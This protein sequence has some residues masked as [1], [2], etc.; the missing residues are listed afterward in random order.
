MN[1]MA[2][3]PQNADERYR[4]MMPN[5]R[6]MML[7]MK[8]G[9]D[10]TNDRLIHSDAD[11]SSSVKRGAARL[12]PFLAES[13]NADFYIFIRRKISWAIVSSSRLL[14]FLFQHF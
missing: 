6:E 9:Q 5:R 13:R 14:Y 3:A 10:I 11:A 7:K 8:L 4:R 1:V 2:P 12:A